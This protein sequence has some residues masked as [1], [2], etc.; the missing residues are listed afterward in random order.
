MTM[1][2]K[3]L[4]LT[5]VLFVL[6]PLW[7]YIIFK[8]AGMGWGRGRLESIKNMIEGGKTHGSKETKTQ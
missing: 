6:V 8:V 3:C 5:V 1:I 7:V 4:C 2:L